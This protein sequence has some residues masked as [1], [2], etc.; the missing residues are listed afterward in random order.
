LALVAML[1]LSFDRYFHFVCDESGQVPRS[2]RDHRTLLK[3]CEARDVEAASSLLK[4]HIL[5]SSETLA[6][7][8]RQPAR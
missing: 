2:H 8:L 5:R 3:H 6:K 1:R 7:R 4:Q